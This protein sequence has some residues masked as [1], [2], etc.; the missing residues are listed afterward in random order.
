M[1]MLKVY[2]KQLLNCTTEEQG[3]EAIF[4]LMGLYTQLLG[5]PMPEMY[6]PTLEA[7]HCLIDFNRTIKFI[8]GL[9]K[10]IEDKQK[11]HPGETINIFEAGCG[12]YA[13]LMTCF[14]TIYTSD[15]VKFFLTDINADALDK[16]NDLYSKLGITNYLIDTIHTDCSAYII[17]ESDRFHIFISETL[18]A[19]MEDQPQ[20]PIM[21]NLLP[22]MKEGSVF[23][24]E[25]VN[26]TLNNQTLVTRVKVYKD[27]VIEPETSIVTR[28]LLYKDTVHY[29]QENTLPRENPI[30]KDY[31]KYNF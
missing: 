5:I 24:P 1:S 11:E 25:E 22:Q 7:A 28:N 6:Q 14:T 26:L 9:H 15:Q 2:S 20:F 3:K 4:G 23:I 27:E 12:P 29:N 16:V 31:F 18:D 21:I 19:G 8:H 13:T 10:A 30:L 17:P